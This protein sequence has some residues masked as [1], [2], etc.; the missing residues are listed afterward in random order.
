MPTQEIRM[1]ELEKSYYGKNQH[2]CSAELH[3][4]AE[5]RNKSN[6]EHFIQ[7]A[8]K[9]APPGKWLD[10][11]C[12]TG[13]FI[14]TAQKS[15]IE[16]EGIE[17]TTSRRELA[18]KLTGALIFDKPIEELDLAPNSFAAVTLTN[19]FSHLTSPARTLSC[20]HNV[21]Q[22]EGILLLRTSEIGA[23]VSKHHNRSWGLGD[24][25]YFLGEHTIERYAENIGFEVIYRE[26]LWGPDS[27][28]RRETFV[29]TGR[30]KLR[31][32]IKKT[33]AYTPGVM[34]LLRWYML[35]IRQ[36]NNP[37]YISTLLLKKIP[38]KLNSTK[39]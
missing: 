15:N 39:E 35:K 22:P 30:S 20:I 23:G 2:V 8:R 33:C 32:F 26:K 28:Y 19:V 18:Q 3:R 1:T 16:I 24:H 27:L 17:P 38:Q 21:L 25:L 11:G 34:P 6:F 12:G 14:T 37:N 4:K 36:R 31:N 7:L 29:R 5:I 13:S 10:M 9:F